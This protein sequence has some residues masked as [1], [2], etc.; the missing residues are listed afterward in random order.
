[1]ASVPDIVGL[2]P[3]AGIARRI[4]PLPG[5]KELFPVGFHE[6]TV[7]GCLQLRPKVV[8]QYLVESMAR[9]GAHRIWMVLGKGKWDIMQYYGDGT[10]F[11]A[12]VAY[13]VTDRL[14]G[15]PYALD[16]AWPWLD[17]A[18]VL[19]GMPDTIFAPR[20]AFTQMYAS[21]VQSGADVTLGVFPTDQ[22]Q[23][24]CP[25][26]MDSKHTVTGMTDKPAH[27]EQ[28]NTWGCA[29]WSPRFSDFM[30]EYLLAQTPGAAEV[31]L[32]SVF[33]AAIE[34]GLLV[35]GV[36]FAGGEYIDVGSP[37]DLV[38]A[39]RRFSE[40]ALHLVAK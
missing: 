8:S 6:T 40:E 12:H 2:I 13:L 4:S 25:V 3:A 30:H 17:A 31:V 9:A 38:L 1:M 23:R 5:S 10:G 24:L 39:V 36:E 32:A 33:R 16:E 28:M 7:D 11:G 19:F 20:D 37:G 14:W 34:K 29:C 35:R 18:T 22:P 15:M 21:H 26:Q 27:T